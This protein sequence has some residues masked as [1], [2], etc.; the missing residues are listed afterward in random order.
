MT[1]TAASS[2]PSHPPNSPPRSAPFGIK[3]WNALHF[4]VSDSGCPR[5]VVPSLLAHGC[6]PYLGAFEPA[7]ATPLDFADDVDNDKS[8]RGS[9]LGDTLVSFVPPLP[10][11]PVALLFAEVQ[12]CL[13]LRVWVVAVGCCGLRLWVA[14]VGCCCGLLWVAFVGCCCRLLWVAFV[15]CCC[16]LLWVAFVGW[17]GHRLRYFAS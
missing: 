14:F 15:G 13:P 7:G 11:P 5:F 9:S 10:L 16:G 17:C 8:F 1:T 12:F 4:V 6:D 3:G 2:E